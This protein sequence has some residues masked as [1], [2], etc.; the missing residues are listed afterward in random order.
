MV[1]HELADASHHRTYGVTIEIEK[2]RCATFADSWQG[3]QGARNVLPRCTHRPILQLTSLTANEQ[4]ERVVTAPPSSLQ[5][6][7]KTGNLG[8]PAEP[9][10]LV[11]ILPP[12]E[13]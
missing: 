7:L 4:R 3:P 10:T 2:D 11:V 6:L 12:N 8:R 13:I 5:Y 9:S 1:Y